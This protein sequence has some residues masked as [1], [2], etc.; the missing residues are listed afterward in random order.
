MNLVVGSTRR[1]VDGVSCQ[2]CNPKESL[3]SQRHLV[4]IK[5]TCAGPVCELWLGC[6]PSPLGQVEARVTLPTVRRWELQYCC[7]DVP[8]FLCLASPC[9][10]WLP[11]YIYTIDNRPSSL[12]LPHPPARFPFPVH[13]G[14]NH[15]VILTP[16]RHKLS[17][18]LPLSTFPTY[19]LC[20]SLARA[21]FPQLPL[22]TSFLPHHSHTASSSTFPSF[23]RLP[24]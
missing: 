19:A 9:P 7:S 2:L 22:V 12:P 6:A 13:S 1:C 24:T 20:Q 3:R 23:S 4:L 16:P 11:G 15:Q 21:A 10:A 18:P 5:A 14:R 17:H 8:A